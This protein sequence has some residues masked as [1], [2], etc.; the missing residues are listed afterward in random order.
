MQ[1]ASKQKPT[2]IDLWRKARLSSGFFSS[3]FA[4]FLTNLAPVPN[5]LVWFI[6]MSTL[7]FAIQV[8]FGKADLKPA[9]LAQ[10]ALS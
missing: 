3:V 1:G 10:Q 5:T 6:S 8:W 2:G 9:S 7:F 4:T